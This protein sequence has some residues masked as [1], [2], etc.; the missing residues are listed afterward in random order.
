MSIWVLTKVDHNTNDTAEVIG[1]F[2]SK[3]EATEHVEK[4]SKGFTG[5]EFCTFYAKPVK[6]EQQ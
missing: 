2:H 4:L 5:D 3:R 1:A 6:E